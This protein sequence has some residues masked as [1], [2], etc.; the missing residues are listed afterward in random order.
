M[1]CVGGRGA[2]ASDIRHLRGW[3][4][5]FCE[6]NCFMMLEESEGDLSEWKRV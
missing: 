4:E 3:A 5:A 1:Q 2:R 6:Q